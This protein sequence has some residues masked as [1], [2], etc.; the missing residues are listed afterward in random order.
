VK[1]VPAISR[2]AFPFGAYL[3]RLDFRAA[4]RMISIGTGRGKIMG[5]AEVLIP[6]SV[7]VAATLTVALLTRLVATGMLNRTIR[8]AL[9]SDPGSVPLLAEKLE[10][11]Q[12]WA[13]AMLGW[14]FIALAAAMALLGLTDDDPDSRRELLR[15]AIIPLIVGVTVLVYVR[16]AAKHAPKV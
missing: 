4:L 11:R 14:V 8:E 7:F 9:R 13:D 10:A 6:I 15:G 5:M 12:P 2:G 3:A 16:F 1:G